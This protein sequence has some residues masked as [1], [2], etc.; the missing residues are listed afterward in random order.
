VH[1]P[2]QIHVHRDRCHS[3]PALSK[4]KHSR[5]EVSR[6]SLKSSEPM[7]SCRRHHHRFLFLFLSAASTAA[8]PVNIVPACESSSSIRDPSFFLIA[9]GTPMCRPNRPFLPLPSSS[10]THPSMPIPA[11]LQRWQ[12]RCRSQP[13]LLLRHRWQ[14][15]FDERS[16]SSPLEGCCR[17][18][19]EEEEALRLCATT[20]GAEG[21][22]T[23][24]FCVLNFDIFGIVFARPLDALDDPFELR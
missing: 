3:I 5:T 20:S 2:R 14:R 6:L 24:A 4:R 10:L 7:G 8:I 16:S 11:S 17:S 9:K 23:T 19:P 18:S 15:G 12:G 1:N 21:A 13:F 22:F